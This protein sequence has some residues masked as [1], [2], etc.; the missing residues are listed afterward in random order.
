MRVLVIGSGGRE[1]ALAWRLAA[2]PS[3]RTVVAWPG[4]GGTALAGWTPP[5]LP[6]ADADA[7]ALAGRLQAQLVV[8]GPEAPLVAGLAD[9]LRAAGIAVC[10]PGADGAR[11]E[12]SK[13]F[14]KQFMQRH[15]VPTAAARTVTDAAE[16]DAALDAVADVVVKADGLA[17]GKGVLLP[18]SREAARRAALAMLD[19]S[20]FG[21]AGRRLLVEERLTG[22]E[23][24]LLAV[25]DGRDYLLLPASQDHKRAGEGDRGPNTGGMG[26]YCP[27]PGVDGA[28]MARLA[29]LVFAPTLA[30]LAEEGIDYRGLLYAG[31]MMTPAG[32]RVLEYNCRFGDPETQAVLPMLDGD[33]GR[34]LASAAAGA[35]DRGAVTARPGAAITVVMAAAGYPGPC[36]KGRPVTGLDPGEEPDRQVFHAGTRRDGERILTAGGRVLAVTARA[37]DLAGAAARCYERLAGIGFEGAWYRRDIGWQVLAA[38]GGG[39]E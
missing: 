12:G 3:V 30:G 18:E 1:H 11:L 28:E 8:L 33:L 36:E 19:G 32:P 23:L 34:L 2:S 22:R 39:D 35:L 21:D 26:A 7:V 6:P 16:L 4:N 24:S 38:A 15:G 31:L 9:R 10:G 14:A 5:D 27:V 20:A 13:V 37:A 25:C 29:E 17:A